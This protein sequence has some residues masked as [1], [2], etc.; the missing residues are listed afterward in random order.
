MKKLLFHIIKPPSFKCYI[1]LHIK[2]LKTHITY[3]Y[4]SNINKNREELERWKAKDYSI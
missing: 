4:V 3:M 1:N 2:L